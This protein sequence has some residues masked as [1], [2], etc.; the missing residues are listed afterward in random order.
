MKKLL[1]LAFPLMMIG[2]R[3][4]DKRVKLPSSDISEY[5][6]VIIDSCEYIKNFG[7]TKLAHKGNCRFCAERRKQEIKELIEEIRK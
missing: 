7:S 4:H 2:C 3:G 6:V 5:E 1:L